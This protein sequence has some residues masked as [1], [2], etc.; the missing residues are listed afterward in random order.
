MR[1]A[2]PD[3]HDLGMASSAAQGFSRITVEWPAGHR[4]EARLLAALELLVAIP[5][6]PSGIALMRDGMGL[7]RSW[8]AHTLLP[9]YTIPGLLLLVVIGGGMSAAAVASLRR[10]QLAR[11]VG[12]T[13]GIV[14]L[15]WLAIETLMLGW[16]GGPQ[17]PLDIA[18][19]GLGAG[20]AAAGLRGLRLTAS[21]R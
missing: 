12:L 16:H 9:D 10:P 14:L 19:G 4:P 3:A 20:L 11:P 1:R 18:Y 5:A 15:G 8:I 7:D 13:A 6:I 17:L 21:G 2:R